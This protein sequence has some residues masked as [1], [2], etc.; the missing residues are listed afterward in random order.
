VTTQSN[1]VWTATT[2]DAWITVSNTGSTTGSGAVTYSVQ[3]NATG[4]GRSGSISVSGQTFAVTQ[5]GS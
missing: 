5:A 1:C 2:T 3:P 4:A